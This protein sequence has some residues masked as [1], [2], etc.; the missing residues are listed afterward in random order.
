MTIIKKFDTEQVS[1]SKFSKKYIAL[2][3][4]GLFVLVILQI[5]ANNTVSMY[6][7]KYEKIS[8]LQES[9]KLDNQLLQNEIAKRS[10]INKIASKSAELGFYS[11]EKIEYIH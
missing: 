3:L 5:W 8:Q 6:G 9:L 2:V 10:S 1:K 11:A 7:E 4:S